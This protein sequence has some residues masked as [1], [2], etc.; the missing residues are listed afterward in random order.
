[1]QPSFFSR[2]LLLVLGLLLLQGSA[3][4]GKSMELRSANTYYNQGEKAQALTWYEKAAEKN[5]GEAQVYAR[6]VELYADKKEWARMREAF[7]QIDGC[8]DKPKKLEEFKEEAQRVIDQQWMGLWNGSIRLF[9]EADSLAAA[10]DNAAAGERYEQ[11]RKR[12]EVALEIL[13]GRQDIRKRLGDI[14]ISE[15]NTLYGNEEGYPLLRKAAEPFEQLAQANPDSLSYS[16]TLIQLYF[17]LRDF[18]LAR[19]AADRALETFPEDTDLLS[20][21]GKARIQQGL[22]QG[23]E[24]KQLLAEA[25]QFIQRA[26][27]HNPD[28]PKLLYNLALLYRDMNQHEKAIQ[29]FKNVVEKADGENRQYAFDAAYSLAVLY[30]QDLPDEMQDP[31]MAAQYFEQCL[32]MQ[33]DNPGL[34]T[35]LGVALMRTGDAEKIARGKKLLGY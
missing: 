8:Q 19:S 25:S 33:P 14:Y 35:N 27:S 23:D 29:A 9:N 18:D 26:V 30:I 4:A 31:N 22:A 11:S 15:F 10:G 32:E 16:I 28:D 5:T 7:A 20:Y 2:A 3:F 6:L 12:L 21:A 13:P 17:N 34:K 24:G 1:M